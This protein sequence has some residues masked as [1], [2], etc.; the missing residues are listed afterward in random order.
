MRVFWKDEPLGDYDHETSL[1]FGEMHQVKKQFGKAYQHPTL[2]IEAALTLVDSLDVERDKQGEP[3]LR[4]GEPVLRIVPN[5]DWDPDAMRMFVVLMGRRVG[6]KWYFE[7]LDDGRLSD[8]KIVAETGEDSSGDE[9]SG[10][11]AGSAANGR[12]QR[13]PRKTRTPSS[14]DASPDSGNTSA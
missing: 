12:S 14:T 13:S 4:G 10:K 5:A 6:K 2:F 3:V 1:T 11:G 8:L 9:E 7:D